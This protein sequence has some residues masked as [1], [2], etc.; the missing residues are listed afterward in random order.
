MVS[1]WHTKILRRAGSLTLA[2][3][4]TPA[5]LLT[6]G[7][8]ATSPPVQPPACQGGQLLSPENPQVQ[9]L[10]SLVDR[11]KMTAPE[12]TDLGERSLTR[13]EFARALVAALENVRQQQVS[14]SK[15]DLVRLEALKAEFIGDLVRTYQYFPALSS[16]TGSEVTVAQVTML[17]SLIQKY[18]PSIKLNR[19]RPLTRTEFGKI[20]NQ[21]GEAMNRQ[22]SRP[23]SSATRNDWEIIQVLATLYAAEMGPPRRVDWPDPNAQFS[24]GGSLHGTVVFP[25]A[26]PSSVMPLS[27]PTFSPP[28]KGPA[29]TVG[30]GTRQGGSL[31]SRVAP[32]PVAPSGEQRFTGRDRLQTRLSERPLPDSDRRPKPDNFNTEDYNLISENPFQ[33]PGLDPLST[34]SIDVDTASYSNVRRFINQG[35]LPP[36]DAVRIEEMIN[37]FA[38]DYPQP[39][40]DQPFSITTEVARAPWNPKH[41][42][43]QIGLQGKQLQTVQPSNLV[44]LVDVSGSM[45]SP[46]K[47]PL[48][49]QS[50]CLLVNELSAQDRVSLVVYAGNA[51]VVLPPTPGNQKERILAA[52]EQLEAGGST[53]GGAGIELAYKLAQQNFLKNGNNRVILATDGDFNV[54]VSSDAELVRLIEQKRNLGVFLTVLGYGYGNYKDGKMEQLAN[55]GNGNYAY[56]DGLREARKVLVQD[57]RATLFTIAKDVKIQVEF[58]PTKV[59]AYRLIGYENRLLRDQDFND[60]TKDA[61]EIGAGHR[62][63]ALYEII[64]TGVESDVKLPKVDPLKYQSVTAPGSNSDELM[65]VKLRYKQP[66]GSTSQLLSQAILDRSTGLEAASNNLK[67]AA[68]VALFGMVLRD[69]EFK[70]QGNFD[71]VLQLANQVKQPDPEGYRSEF[72]RLVERSKPLLAQKD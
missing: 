58:N 55:K 33:R 1:F 67:L 34:F 48:V 63:T 65:Q 11:Y 2:V 56:I 42:L 51:G 18:S 9:L 20:L 22:R 44:F 60:D 41:K 53:A 38:Y 49:K 27:R 28:R 36:K 57:L 54:G 3:L 61:G 52:I 26:P 62:V 71:L 70:G 5:P 25:V 23:P 24:T 32:A 35:S 7:A 29:T 50:L 68:A 59:Q 6:V 39:A 45:Q 16:L 14:L 40:G 47:L 17:Q 15:A 46:N 37:Y 43:V 10:R 69:S 19:D 31:P 21:V 13:F 72:L 4:L 30:G 66:Q 8:G 64:P 12:L